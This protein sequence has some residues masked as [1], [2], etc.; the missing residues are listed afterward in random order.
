[1]IGKST[2]TGN[3]SSWELTNSRPTVIESAWDQAGHTVCMAQSI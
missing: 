2:E 1:M 3:L